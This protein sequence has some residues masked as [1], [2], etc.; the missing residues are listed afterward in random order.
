MRDKIGLLTIK[1]AEIY[2]ASTSRCCEKKGQGLNIANN[3]LIDGR[4]SVA[5]GTVGVMTD[6]LEESVSYAKAREQHGW[7]LEKSS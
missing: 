3:A 4:L 1:N 7:P 6:C 2:F 5:A